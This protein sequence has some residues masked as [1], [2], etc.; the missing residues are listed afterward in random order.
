MARKTKYSFKNHRISFRFC[1]L[2]LMVFFRTGI[3]THTNQYFVIEYSP[4]H[5]SI[6]K[7][8]RLYIYFRFNMYKSQSPAQKLF[9]YQLR[10]QSSEVAASRRWSVRT[11][12][13]Q[14][15]DCPE[16]L[17]R[18]LELLA[19]GVHKNTWINRTRETP[20][21]LWRRRASRISERLDSTGI[22]L[23]CLVLHPLSHS[24]PRLVQHPAHAPQAHVCI[25]EQDPRFL[26]TQIK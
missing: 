16:R 22:T 9:L 26:K 14:E 8:R 23:R 11:P 21:L 20:C 5:L 4:D 17:L 18:L 19:P 7:H 24:H 13:A 15:H 6:Q 1:N 3:I 12:A 2:M 25:A 10:R